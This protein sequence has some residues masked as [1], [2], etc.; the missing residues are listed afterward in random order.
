MIRH[1]HTFWLLTLMIIHKHTYWLLTVV[2][3]LINIYYWTCCLVKYISHKWWALTI[4][5]SQN[6][7]KCPHPTWLGT[8]LLNGFSVSC[9]VILWYH[10]YLLKYSLVNNVMDIFLGVF[11]Y[12]S[13][14]CHFRNDY[15]FIHISYKYPSWWCPG[16]YNV[17]RRE[18]YPL[19]I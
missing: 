16:G 19:T 8:Y 5:Q 12:N 3:M 15:S 13:L 9:Y 6:G 10:E 2:H 4:Q 14:R 1:K 18:I 7:R 11:N 17:M